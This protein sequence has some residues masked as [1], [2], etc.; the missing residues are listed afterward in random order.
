MSPRGRRAGGRGAR[1]RGKRVRRDLPAIPVPEPRGSPRRAGLRGREVRVLHLP[2]ARST[3][4][5]RRTSGASCVRTTCRWC[6]PTTARSASRSRRKRPASA[7]SRRSP[8]ASARSST[9]WTCCTKASSTARSRSSVGRRRSHDPCPHVRPL[10]AQGHH[11]PRRR[12]GHRH[13]RPARHDPHQRRDETV[14]GKISIFN[15]PY[16][17]W[18]YCPLPV[19]SYF[20]VSLPA[21]V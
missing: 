7:T 8:T 19:F 4:T 11:R 13:L 10:P 17:I 6:R 2:C 1:P 20:Q 15:F 12:R 18:S 5:I 9:A 16:R 3:S 14:L 21:S